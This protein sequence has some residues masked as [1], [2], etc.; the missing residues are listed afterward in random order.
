MSMKDTFATIQLNS[1]AAITA[2]RAL[3]KSQRALSRLRYP[4]KP[5]ARGTISRRREK[6]RKAGLLR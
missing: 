6:I 1:E 4:P 2:F 3:D 5:A